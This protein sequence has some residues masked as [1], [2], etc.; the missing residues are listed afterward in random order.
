[1]L[2]HLQGVPFLLPDHLLSHESFYQLFILQD[3]L[4][5]LGIGHW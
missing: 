3:L 1:M 2:N 5:R 4:A